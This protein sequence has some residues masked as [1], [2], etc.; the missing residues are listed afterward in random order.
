MSILPCSEEHVLDCIES[1]MRLFRSHESV[2][3]GGMGQKEMQL[4]LQA[5]SYDKLLERHLPSVR[6][7]EIVATKDIRLKFEDNSVFPILDVGSFVVEPGTETHFHVRINVRY[8]EC[9]H[10]WQAR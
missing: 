8:L 7:Q 10:L 4:V 5:S 6:N 2:G 3:T 1:E 9:K